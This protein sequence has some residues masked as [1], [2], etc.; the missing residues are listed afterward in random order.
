MKHR[1]FALL[2]ASALAAGCIAGVGSVAAPANAIG[3]QANYYY[4]YFKS[5]QICQARGAEMIKHPTWLSY[6]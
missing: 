3:I 2:G 5:L 4:N 1:P 6:R